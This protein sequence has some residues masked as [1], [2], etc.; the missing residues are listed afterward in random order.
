M[1]HATKLS[2][3]GWHRPLKASGGEGGSSAA[4]LMGMADSQWGSVKLITYQIRSCR[5][6]GQ[7]CS[8]G[9]LHRAKRPKLSFIHSKL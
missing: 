9:I 8:G 3:V 5:E 2:S 6:V 1:S 7:R 4:S